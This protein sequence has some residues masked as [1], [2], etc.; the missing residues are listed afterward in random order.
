MTYQKTTWVNFPN[1]STPLEASRLNNLETQ[2]E[3][4]VSYVDSEIGAV[5]SELAGRP[6]F[7]EVDDAILSV[8][9]ELGSGSGEQAPA[10]WVVTD[11]RAPSGDR[12]TIPTHL[13]PTGGQATHPSVIRLDTPL[14]GYRYWM[15]M[16][17]Y[18]GGSDAHEDPN[19]VAS[20]DG[21]TW[22]VPSGLVN[23][24]DDAPGSPQYNS[25]TDIVWAQG[26][27]WVIWRYVD[28]VSQ[29]EQLYF[30][31]SGDGISWGP[32]TLLYQSTFSESRLVSPSLIF[33]DGFWTMWA[34]DVRVSPFKLVRL[35]TT[36]SDLSRDEWG[37]AQ[38]CTLPGKAGRDHW[39]IGIR[40]VGDKFLGLLNDCTVGSSGS[41]GDLYVMESVDGLTWSRTN[42]P[43]IQRPVA[44]EFDNLYRATFIPEFEN[45][46]LG[47]RIW[48]SAWLNSPVTWNIF[49]TWASVPEEKLSSQSGSRS[50]EVV[51]VGGSVSGT[52]SFSPAFS[53]T[54][55]VSVNVTSSRLTLSVSSISSSSFNYVITNWSGGNAPAGAILRWAAIQL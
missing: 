41:N 8:T 1:T 39:H 40:R 51:P 50:L 54:P 49:R 36:G 16:T 22:V 19:V 5:S 3:R 20:N 11:L 32:K 44:S 13:S 29:V 30:R 42:T 52:V 2:Y 4:V 23:P 9:S 14:S 12:L 21:I 27:L 55:H 15:A 45:G 31:S 37:S 26:K 10:S 35:Q 48:F 18:P 46:I 7:D 6:T 28:T 47:L 38:T 24:L 53:S 17:P 34:I 25:D 33:E 43:L